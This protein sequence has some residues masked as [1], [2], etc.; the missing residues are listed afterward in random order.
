VPE[1]YPRPVPV[2]P[3][4]VTKEINFALRPSQAGLAD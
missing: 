1:A 4:R 2:R 3:G